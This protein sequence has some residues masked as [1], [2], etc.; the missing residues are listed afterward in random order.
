MHAHLR[1]RRTLLAAVLPAALAALS[2]PA[3]ADANV[4]GVFSGRDGN[5]LQYFHRGPAA[6]N[7]VDVSARDGAVLVSDPRGVTPSAGPCRSVDPTTVSCAASAV[8]QIALVLGPGNDLATVN[9]DLPTSVFG[10][11]GND[12]Y[13]GGQHVGVSRVTFEGGG[14]FD[15]AIYGGSTA[16][17]TVSKDETAN[18]GRSG[19][20]RD[21]IRG[22][23]EHLVG[24]RFNDSLN[25]DDAAAMEVFTGNGGNDALSGNG[26]PDAFAM[27]AAPDGA[28][29][30]FG[31]D[32]VD[33][34]DYGLRTRA[35]NVNL[36]DGGAD[37]GE[38]GEGDEI[39]QVEGARGGSAG[40]VLRGHP[41]G[42]APMTLLGFAGADRITGARGGDTLDG[43]AGRDTI[44]GEAG[45]DLI[46]A[47]DRESDTVSCG[48]EVDTADL[49]PGLDV[50][51]AGCEKVQAVGKLRLTPNS[52]DARTG[53][54]TRVRLSW[55]HPQSGTRLRSVTLRLIENGLAVG[56][57]TLRPREG[58]MTADGGVRLIRR[59]SRITRRE[60]T[61]SARLA[62]GLDPSLAGRLLRLEVEATDT[63]GRRQLE[64]D[65]GTIRVAQ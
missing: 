53:K 17:V 7:Q 55:R 18:D 34:V 61:A 62:V 5:L 12:R 16:G 43:G 59:A 47:R 31:G 64:R 26:G 13:F 52:I 39:R 50:V 9:T 54:P 28:D 33:Q 4:V 25:G 40:D 27:T 11:D 38:S 2:L 24:S 21:N 19:R 3:V 35:V 44:R 56:Q 60:R 15:E 8:Q 57:I 46:Q 42:T 29:R 6:A 37:D 48:T 45:N 14:G 51:A 41:E 63:R 58:R 30:V 10:E 22:D 23:V 65:A 36:S 20:D 1:S 49:E 32:G